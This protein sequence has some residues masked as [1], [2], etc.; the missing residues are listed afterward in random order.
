MT[1]NRKNSRS[2][3]ARTQGYD[4]VRDIWVDVV[5]TSNSAIRVEDVTGGGSGGNPDTPSLA[6]DGSTILAGISAS[7][8]VELTAVSGQQGILVTNLNSTVIHISLST[9][10][11]GAHK[12]IRESEEFEAEPYAGSVFLYASASASY[13]VD[14]IIKS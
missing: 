2:V 12:S 14:R 7:E 11:S 8:S 13:Q 5:M 1:T 6:D 9:G 4:P 10:V 3:H